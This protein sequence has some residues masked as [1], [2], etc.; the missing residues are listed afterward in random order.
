[1]IIHV[2]ASERPE[3]IARSRDAT[4]RFLSV[5]QLEA[6][7]K[8]DQQALVEHE[9]DDPSADVE[10]AS[11]PALTPVVPAKAAKTKKTPTP[12]MVP[13]PT[14]GDDVVTPDTPPLPTPAPAVDHRAAPTIGREFSRPVMKTLEKF[15]ALMDKVR[16]QQA[17][18]AIVVLEWGKISTSS[19]TFKAKVNAKLQEI[20][21][22]IFSNIE[23]LHA[24]EQSIDSELRSHVKPD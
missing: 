22:Q 13:V 20:R 16:D 4:G 10:P 8:P 14:P 9:N 6:L 15:Q 17:D 21:N 11:V 2:A 23:L 24:L 5:R 7:L 19:D 3:F 1:V 12:E 18:A